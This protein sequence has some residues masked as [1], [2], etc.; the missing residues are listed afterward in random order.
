MKN[1]FL[2]YLFLVP[3]QHVFAD[4]IPENSHSVDKC[5]K[6]IN[7]NDFPSISIVA[8]IKHPSGNDSRAFIIDANTCLEKGYKFNSFQIFG[9]AKSYLATKSIDSIDWEKDKNVLHVNINIEP[10]GGYLDNLNSVS[11]IE[12][13][14]QIH[15]ISNNILTLY[16][17]KEI[18]KFNN[19][20]PISIQT[21]GYKSGKVIK[22]KEYKIDDQSSKNKHS[23]LDFL[24]ALFMTIFIETSVLLVFFKTRYKNLKIK[25]K[26]IVGSG[27]LASFSTLPYLWYILPIF[28]SSTWVYI[29]IG[30]ITVALIETLIIVSMLKIDIKKAVLVSLIANLTSFLVG[31]LLNV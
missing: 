7:T 22:L 29:S 17:C 26:L 18:T 9:L 4:I 21:F 6:I 30:E 31:L 5:V 8:Y 16:K 1:I 25:T 23:T 27:I 24:R 2:A 13:Y 11:S 3:W 19:G 20:R 14:Y 12:E 15:E 28:F 10:Y